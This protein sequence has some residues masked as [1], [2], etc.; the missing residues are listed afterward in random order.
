M[1]YVFFVLEKNHQSFRISSIICPPFY[2]KKIT[3]TKKQKPKNKKKQKKNSINRLP[4]MLHVGLVMRRLLHF[5]WKKMP[6]W[7]QKMKVL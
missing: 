2:D 5:C 7:R 6:I 3:K 1:W 4:Y